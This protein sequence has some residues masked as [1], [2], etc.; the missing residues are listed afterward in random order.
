MVEVLNQPWTKTGQDVLKVFNVSADRGLNAANVEENRQKYGRNQLKKVKKKGAWSILVKQF[1]SPI[2][3]LLVVAAVISFAFGDW[4]EGVAIVVVIL[5]N[6][7]IGFF[8]EL[9]A[10]R[11]ME[12]LHKLSST[13]AKVRR[14]GHL[15]EIPAEEVVSGDILVLEAGDSIAADLRLIEVANLQADESALTGESVPVHKGLDPLDAGVP[16]AERI[17]MLFKGT[18]V[19][20]GS[21]AG[22][23]VSTGMETE[24]GHISSLV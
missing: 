9:Q 21:G 16:L 19:T 20:S 4:V 13:Q 11:S 7:V 1:K 2:V 12:A 18:V 14:D 5:I 24:L 10:V 6:A 15:Q 22:V 8:T 3:V 23:V 17:N